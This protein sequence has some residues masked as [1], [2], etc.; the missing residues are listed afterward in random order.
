[1]AE[2]I[3]AINVLD[4]NVLKERVRIAEQSAC[5]IHIDVADGSFTPHAVWHNPAELRNFQ[6]I[7]KLEIHLMV[8]N[9]DEQITNWLIPEVA[10]IITHA[11]VARDP[12]NIIDQCH[13]KHIE[14]GIS[15]CP[16][17]SWEELALFFGHADILQLLAVTP[18]P[19]GQVFDLRTI[20]KIKNLKRVAP[21]MP[22]EIDGG[23]KIGVA[24]DCA[25]AG[26]DFLVVGSALFGEGVKFSGAF[27][28]LTEDVA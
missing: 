22:L 24:H 6:S 7:A 15:I 20:E 10:R 21:Q 5:F 1:M 3:P 18:G 16:D 17:T 14:A 28:R 2:I 19:S 27:K 11:E 23:I 9:P 25:L 12:Q 4:F 8:S 13:S 26:A